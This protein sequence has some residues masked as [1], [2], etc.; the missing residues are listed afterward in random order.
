MAVTVS[1]PSSQLARER[2]LRHRESETSG[3]FDGS[4]RRRLP[5]IPAGD[6]VCTEAGRGQGRREWGRPSPSAMRR[7]LLHP[8][9]GRLGCSEYLARHSS[10][11]ARSVG[12]RSP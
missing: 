2:H 12:L 6:I 9:F 4:F 11:P 1:I 8:G 10:A 7:G 5:P 3:L